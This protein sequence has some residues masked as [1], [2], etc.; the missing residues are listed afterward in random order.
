MKRGSFLEH[1]LS[2]NLYLEKRD[3]VRKIV[4]GRPL[5]LDG[6]VRL[7]SDHEAEPRL[8]RMAR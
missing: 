8:D 4:T 1:F 5:A 2:K 6:K 3:C 7:G